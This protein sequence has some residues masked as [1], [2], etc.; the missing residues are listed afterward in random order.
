MKRTPSDT[1]QR[2]HNNPL[3]KKVVGGM[4]ALL[5]AGALGVMPANADPAGAPNNTGTGQTGSSNSTSSSS[6]TSANSGNDSDRRETESRNR[7]ALRAKHEAETKA[8]QAAEASQIPG[9]PSDPNKNPP[10]DNVVALNKPEQGNGL[11]L[12]RDNNVAYGNVGEALKGSK[13]PIPTGPA[14]DPFRGTVKSAS[15]KCDFRSL[16]HNLEDTKKMFP[17]HDCGD[18][19]PVLHKCDYGSDGWRCYAL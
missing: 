9:P 17:D 16:T 10:S 2:V 4:T 8:R 12:D 15:S 19:D 1:K 7:E 11:T 3:T 18:W 13:P 14:N 5:L 6:G